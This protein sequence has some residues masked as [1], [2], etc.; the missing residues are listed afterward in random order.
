MI[1]DLITLGSSPFD[2]AVSFAPEEIGLEGDNAELKSPVK[3]EGKLTRRIVQADIEGEISAAIV[4]ECSRCLQPV[5]KS[6]SFPFDVSYVAPEN[7]SE[8]KEIEL[9][10]NDLDVALFD[11]QNIDIKELAREQILLNLPTQI[12]C[13]EDCKGLCPKCGANRNLIDCNCEEKEIDPRWQSLRELKI[14]NEK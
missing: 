5:E 3:V 9:R 6:L 2:F 10:E 14:K 1:I 13:S 12:F 4:I 11:G 8:A 7:Y